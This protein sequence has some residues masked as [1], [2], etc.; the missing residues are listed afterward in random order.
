M[1]GIVQGTVSI[2]H[3]FS[4]LKDCTEQW[5]REV[6]KLTTQCAVNIQECMVFSRRTELLGKPWKDSED[7]L[8][9]M[10][11]KRSLKSFI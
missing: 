10:I 9:E 1:A 11:L 8:K 4:A 6:S 7:F 3:S 5:G 2:K